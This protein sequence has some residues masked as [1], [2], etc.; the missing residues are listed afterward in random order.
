MTSRPGIRKQLTF[1]YSV[2][3]DGSVA[4][5]RNNFPGLFAIVCEGCRAALE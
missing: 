1:F 4:G 2:I 3:G 5:I